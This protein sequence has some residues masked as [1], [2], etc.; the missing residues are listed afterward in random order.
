MSLH[1]SQNKFDRLQNPPNLS[2]SCQ[3]SEKYMPEQRENWQHTEREDR[4]GYC[5][6]EAEVGKSDG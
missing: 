5:W 6:Y 3:D 4:A 2:Y 1:K